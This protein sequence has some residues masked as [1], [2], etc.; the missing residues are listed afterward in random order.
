MPCPRR[1]GPS[2]FQQAASAGKGPDI[3]A[4]AHDR[5]GGWFAS[6]L[7]HA[8]APNRVKVTGSVSGRRLIALKIEFLPQ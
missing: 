7:I 2:K 8:V 4:C 1:E 3:C 5:I 6:G